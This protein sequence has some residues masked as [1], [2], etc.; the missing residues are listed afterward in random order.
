MPSP[1]ITGVKNIT[2]TVTDGVST[3]AVEFRM[4]VPTEK[5]VQDV[6]DAIDQIRG[7]LPGDDRGAHRHPDRRR[8]SGDHDLRGLLPRH[9]DRGAVA[10]SSMTPSSATCRASPASAAST[11]TAAP[12]A[13]SASSST[14]S[15]STAS[16]SR[17][18]RCSAAARA[19]PTPTSARAGPK[20]ARANRRSAPLATRRRR[21]SWPRPPSRCPRGGSCSWPIWA[22]VNDTYEELRSFS[23]FNGDQV[24]AFSVFRAKGASE[25]SVAETGER[26]AGR[27]SARP[28]PTC[29]SRWSMTRSS[30]PT[31]T[32]RPRSTRC[33]KAR[34][35]PC[36]WCCCSCAT[37]A[38]R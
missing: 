24:V 29:R 11:A 25:V 3:T 22:T 20:S 18:R 15:S 31:A 35:W 33:S 7:D 34:S 9:D 12:T 10:G 26:R 16:A 32:T 37:G 4:E 6:K 13:R 28:T 2:S 36:S 1:G 8:R 30:T 17:R 27:R 19:R 5:A 38:R 14:R 21:M 23:R